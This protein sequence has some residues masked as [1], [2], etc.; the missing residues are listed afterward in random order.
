MTGEN[1]MG[2]QRNR[3]VPWGF[4]EQAGFTLV[5]LMVGMVVAAIIVAAGFTV[6]TTTNKSLQANE[7]IVDMQQNVRMA[8]EMLT[9]DIKSAGFGSPGVAIG[10]C[11]NGIMPG[12]QNPTGVDTGPDSV[13][14]LVPTT[15]ASGSNRWTLSA[16]TVSSGITSITL[17]PG[18]VTDMVS[19][20]LIANQSYI[21]I[22]GAATVLVTGLSTAASTL[23]VS[24]PPP[25]WFQNADQVYLLQCIRY[26]VVLAPDPT[27]ICGGNAP[28]LTRGV[29]GVTVGPNAEGP[30]AEG[31]EDLQL[32]Y[33]CDGCVATINGGVPDRVID[34]QSP[35]SG[36]FDQADYLSNVPWTA[37]P[38]TPDKIQMVQVALVA[39]QSKN[40]QGFGEGVGSTASPAQTV[41]S[42]HPLPADSN[43]RRRVLVRTVE[44]RNVGL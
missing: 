3:P 15:K 42:D 32:A 4:T 1:T 17:Q 12:D 36:S 7:Q 44:T 28:C 10:N 41:T 22:G 40:D 38:L 5:E 35:F 11:S 2:L 39:R 18:A 21:S 33:A 24:I 6:L 29:A 26:R 43:H 9:R 13:Q 25:L 37:A 8:M 30:I 19:S 23:S 31:V 27:N 34:D 20:G 16:A 14:L